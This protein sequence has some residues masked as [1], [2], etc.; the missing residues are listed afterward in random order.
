[1]QIVS[2]DPKFDGNSK[3]LTKLNVNKNLSE[4][5]LQVEITR[6]ELKENAHDAGII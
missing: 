4:L 2:N 1:M 6:Q 3:C 5:I